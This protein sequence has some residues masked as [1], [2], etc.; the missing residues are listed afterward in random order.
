M[1]EL[2]F[3]HQFLTTTHC[4]SFHKEISALSSFLYKEKQNW[5]KKRATIEPSF[6]PVEKKPLLLETGTL[7]VLVLEH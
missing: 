5:S 3:Q 2:K 1:I 4:N 7:I 6:T